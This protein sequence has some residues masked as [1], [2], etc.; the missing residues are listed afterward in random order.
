MS[1]RKEKKQLMPA[2]GMTLLALEPRY[3]YDAA[4][5]AAL[6][7]VRN[8][9]QANSV[10][11]IAELQAAQAVNAS[12]ENSLLRNDFAASSEPQTLKE[13]P[14]GPTGSSVFALSGAFSRPLLQGSPIGYLWTFPA[15]GGGL[16]LHGGDSYF[17]ELS[18]ALKEGNRPRNHA[19]MQVDA[20]WWASDIQSD[21]DSW[22]E[23]L[24]NAQDQGNVVD[25]FLENIFPSVME[26]EKVLEKTIEIDDLDATETYLDIP[27]NIDFAR[28]LDNAESVV[29]T[30]NENAR[31][32]AE[33]EEISKFNDGLDQESLSVI[34]EQPGEVEKEGILGRAGD[35]EALETNA[36]AVHSSLDTLEWQLWVN[37]MKDMAS[38]LDVG[39]DLLNEWENEESGLSLFPPP[40]DNKRFSAQIQDDVEKFDKD[41]DDLLELMGG[42]DDDD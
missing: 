32:D 8:L 2:T 34:V 10:S 20:Y 9:M 38:T 33:V 7:E 12:H 18:E 24:N 42:F 21:Y 30:V 11:N 26:N 41:V 1:K 6:D 39:H 3:M 13:I 29:L 27:E 17:A 16:S 40:L 25:D 23:S 14:Y 15:E 36:H 22:I 35:I 5:F 31:L 4:G 19:E 37:E 28:Q